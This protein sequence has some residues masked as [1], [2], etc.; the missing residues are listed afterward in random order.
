MKNDL[1]VIGLESTLKKFVKASKSARACVNHGCLK[2]T[3]R[4]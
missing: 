2:T 4:L 3:A 1:P